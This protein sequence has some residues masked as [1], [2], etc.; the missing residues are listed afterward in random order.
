[1][2]SRALSRLDR[3]QPDGF[4][5][6][7]PDRQEGDRVGAF[8]IAEQGI[9]RIGGD[10]FRHVEVHRL[11]DRRVGHGRR[12]V[13]FR[14]EIGGHLLQR[15]EAERLGWPEFNVGRALGLCGAGGLKAEGGELDGGDD[16]KKSATRK[17][18]TCRIENRGNVNDGATLEGLR[19][20]RKRALPSRVP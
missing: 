9:G 15:V 19:G 3:E 12:Y 2:I 7:I 17:H 1:M 6:E 16:F 14:G 11:D 4:G 20:F 18:N 13:G 8:A 10:A 5:E